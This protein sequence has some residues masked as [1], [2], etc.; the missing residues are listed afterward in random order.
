M[1]GGM[2]KAV[3]TSTRKIG[4]G[5]AEGRRSKGGS[6]EKERGEEEVEEIGK[7]KTSGSKKSRGEVGN[8]GRGRRSGKVRDRGKEV[9][10]RRIS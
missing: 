4:M 1:S 5:E 9:S 8:I 10:A 2:W 6:V 3:E 7:G